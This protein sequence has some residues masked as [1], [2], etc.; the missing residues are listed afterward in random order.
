V[1]QA[2]GTGAKWNIG[3]DTGGWEYRLD[4]RRRAGDAGVTARAGG[5]GKVRREIFRVRHPPGTTSPGDRVKGAY[6]RAVALAPAI[7]NPPTSGG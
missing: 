4:L 1:P 2:G 5:W 6:E 3:S 7:A